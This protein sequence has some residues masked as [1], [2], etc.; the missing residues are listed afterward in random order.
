VLVG[1]G[2]FQMTGME[3]TTVVRYGLDPIVILLDNGG[4]GTE[5]P[6]LDGP[7]N[8]IVPWRYSRIPDVL[9]GGR[10]YEVRTEGELD[11]ALVA[12]K[13]D[14]S[15]FSIVH[16]HLDRDDLSPALQRLTALLA[17]RVRQPEPRPDGVSRPSWS[18]TRTR[19]PGEPGLRRSRA[20]G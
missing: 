3:L 8:D 11:A 16:V 19:R 7:F 20:R 4:Y 10:G 2:A 18:A 14:R 5:R 15:G 12:A 9:G 17:E 13:A 1:D 6:M